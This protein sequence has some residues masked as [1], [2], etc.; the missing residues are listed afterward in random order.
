M[1]MTMNYDIMNKWKKKP[2]LTRRIEK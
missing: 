1:Y 2:Y